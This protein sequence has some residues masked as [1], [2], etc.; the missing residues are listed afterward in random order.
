M[1]IF[2]RFIAVFITAMLIGTGLFASSSDAVYQKVETYEDRYAV[3]DSWD[4][5]NVST[6]C[7]EVLVAVGFDESSPT[8]S[9][10]DIEVFAVDLSGS[11]PV[12]TLTHQGSWYDSSLSIFL[13]SNRKL[14]TLSGFVDL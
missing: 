5:T 1:R 3:I 8:Q 14:A 11:V 13:A 12:F 9:Y 10:V 2:T 4:C 6:F 7:T